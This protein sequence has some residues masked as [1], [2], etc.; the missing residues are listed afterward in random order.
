MEGNNRGQVGTCRCD[1]GANKLLQERMVKGKDW[2]VSQ[3]SVGDQVG[4][5]GPDRLRYACTQQMY[6]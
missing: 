4:V 3:L 5:L 6:V 1:A 2:T